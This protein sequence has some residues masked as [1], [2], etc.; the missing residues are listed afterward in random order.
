MDFVKHVFT[1]KAVGPDIISNK[2]LFAVR[3]EITKPLTLLF[4]KSLIEKIF[5]DQWKIAHVIPLFKN[6]DKSLP[7]N[8]RPVALSSCVGKILEKKLCLKT[9]LTI[10][11]RTNFYINSNLGS[12][13][14]IQLHISWLNYITKYW[15][16]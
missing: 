8:Y 2:M 13:Q 6:G 12:Y 3:N 9:F 1:N 4:K 14:G 15:L 11:T 5:P 7:S 10:C 16:L